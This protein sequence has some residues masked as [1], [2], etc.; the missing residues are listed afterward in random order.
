MTKIPVTTTT[1]LA[2]HFYIMFWTQGILS[3]IMA[4]LVL[5]YPP[6]ITLLVA[7][8][9]LWIGIMAFV[10]AWRVGKFRKELS[11]IFDL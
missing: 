7:A 2:R 6:I 9:F 11:D 5:L 8:T 4:V 10:M 1:N 3:I